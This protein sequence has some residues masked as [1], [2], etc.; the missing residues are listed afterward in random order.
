MRWVGEALERLGLHEAID[1]RA[2][3]GRAI[4]V[5]IR[6]GSPSLPFPIRVFLELP[7]REVHR[8]GCLPGPGSRECTRIFHSQSSKPSSPG[9]SSPAAAAVMSGLE[10]LP[11]QPE[12]GLYQKLKVR[13]L[14]ARPRCAGPSLGPCLPRPR[15]PGR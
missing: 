1:V 12:S 14:T 9:C 4:L 11:L 8:F 7:V 10:P 5:A 15:P 3:L 13:C 6:Y 2:A